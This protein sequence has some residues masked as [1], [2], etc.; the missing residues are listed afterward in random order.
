MATWSEVKKLIKRVP[1]LTV[2]AEQGAVVQVQ[3][4]FSDGRSHRAFVSRRQSNVGSEWLVI[5]AIVAEY[6]PARLAAVARLASTYFCG[7]VATVTINGATAIVLQEGIPIA[8]LDPMELVSPLSVL[9]ATADYLEQGLTGGRD[10][11]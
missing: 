8:N 6:S 4:A 11:F 10:V 5:S 1:G 9:L 3:Y 7:G 2:V